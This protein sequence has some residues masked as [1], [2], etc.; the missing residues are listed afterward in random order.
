MQGREREA[1][2]PLKSPEREPKIVG[3]AGHDRGPD[4]A[5]D[6]QGAC[7]DRMEAKLDVPSYLRPPSERRSEPARAYPYRRPHVRSAVAYFDGASTNSV[8]AVRNRRSSEAPGGRT[9]SSPFVARTTPVPARAADGAADR[10]SLPSADD[11]PHDRSD[12]GRSRDFSRVLLHRGTGLS[13][14][15]SASIAISAPPGAAMRSN[16]SVSSP[17]PETLPAPAA[18]E[19]CPPTR[20]PA[21]SASTPAITSAELLVA[22][23]SWPDSAVSEESGVSSRRR[24]VDPSGTST[25]SRGFAPSSFR[26]KPGSSRVTGCVTSRLRRAGHARLAPRG[27]G[28]PDHPRHHGGG[29]GDH[30]GFAAGERARRRGARRG[31]RRDPLAAAVHGR[32]PPRTAP[33]PSRV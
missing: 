20:L 29:Q 33:C 4:V 30:Y 18:C 11:S 19:T 8:S 26:T 21:G 22:V 9:T 23:N 1:R 2:P 10:G 32:R 31:T 28:V 3:E 27:A 25:R 24:R 13:C 15:G 5:P 17:R 6:D 14:S 12:S 16:S 7:Q